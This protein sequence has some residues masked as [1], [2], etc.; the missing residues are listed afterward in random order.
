MIS[1]AS[2]F[3]GCSGIAMLPRHVSRTDDKGPVASREGATE[4][5]ADDEG[6]PMVDSIGDRTSSVRPIGGCGVAD[7]IERT[8]LI[9]DIMRLIR[10]PAMP[11]ATRMAGM[12]LIGWLARRRPD[13]T[14]HAIGIDEARESERRIR[15]ARKVR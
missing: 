2:K 9:A 13:E 4:R 1:I 6:E 5:G 14:P 12:N 10:E 15:A 7:E 3:D 8:R 11:E